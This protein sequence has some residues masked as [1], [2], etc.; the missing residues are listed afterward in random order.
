MSVATRFAPSPTGL[1]HIGNVRTALI[2]WLFTRKSGGSFMLRLDDTDVERSRADYA[3]AIETDLKWLGLAWDRF[4][5]QMDRLAR[6]SAAAERL[7]AS[8]RLYACYETA[9]ELDL[10]RKI[11]LNAG[12]PPRYDRAALKLSPAERA[13]LEAE[14]R[15][16]HWRFRLEDKPIEWRDLVRG[17]VHIEAHDVSDPV[18]VRSN[19]YPLYTLSSVVDDVDFGITHIIRG[20]DHVTNTAVQIQIFEALGGAVPAFAHLA[21]LADAEGKGLS[22]RLGSLSI[23]ELR[24]SGI[25]PEAISS[26]LAR[27][28]TSQ[29]VEAFVDLAPLI[30]GF[31]WASF[32]RATPKFD[33]RDLETLNARVLHA[34]PFAAAAPRLAAAGLADAD[35]HFWLAVRGNIG[36]IA[37]AHEWWKVC[38]GEVTPAIEDAPLIA[39]A[40]DMLP[41][42]P[43]SAETWPRWTK[44]VGEATGKKGRA[45]FH[46]LRLALTGRETGPEMKAML[47]LIGRARVLARLSTAARP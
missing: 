45:L 34:L 22:K 14:G 36:R 42:E 18:L 47:P 20:E 41:T 6:Y 19:S 7:K 8:D 21:L 13:Q 43:W 33:P 5:R 4:A 30:A 44:S 38:R 46:P 32:S 9:D 27:I 17:P 31:D 16:P 23:D 39:A 25:E 2:N 11:A 26:L 24:K 29:P 35:E 3:A 15:K 37:E 1:L 12:R 40:R 28:G 10:K